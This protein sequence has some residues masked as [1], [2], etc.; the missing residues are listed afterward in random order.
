MY[1]NTRKRVALVVLG[2]IVASSTL[3][4]Q[5]YDF[6]VGQLY[7]K[8]TD[9]VTRKVAVVP[10]NSSD[11]YYNNAPTGAITIPATVANGGNT[12]SI[13]SIG[14]YAFSNCSG[15]T[16]IT[17]PSG[18]TSIE[19]YAFSSCSGLTSITIPSSVTSIG[20][21]AFFDCSGLTSITIPNNVTSIG[22]RAFLWCSGLKYVTFPGHINFKNN[23]DSTYDIDTVIIAGG[24]DSICTSSF[25]GCSKIKYISIPNSVTSIG[26]YAFSNCSGLTSI[27]IPSSVTS[28]G[29]GAFSSCS[30]LTSIT[31]PSSVTSIGGG[32]FFDCSGLTSIIIP[33]S[34]TKIEN[35][36]FKNCTSLASVNLPHGLD[37][38]GSSN[39]NYSWDYGVF[40]GCTSLTSIDI[41][42][43][44]RYIGKNAFS[45]CSGLTSITIPNS[46]TKIDNGAFYNCTSLA[47]VALGNGV[48]FIGS[49][50]F[51]YEDKG[52]F[53]D[54]T[55]LT[56][57]DIPNSVRYIG[58]NAF[59]S[60]SGLT[61]ITIPSGVTSIEERAF[62]DCG[63]LTSITIP[64]SVTK[65]QNG[66]FKNCTRLTSVN[67]SNGLESIGSNYY[68]EGVFEGCTSLTSINI[69]NSVTSIRMRAFSGCSGLNSVT[70]HW[71]RP[72]RIDRDVFDSIALNRVKLTVPQGT[73]SLY[74]SAD[75]WKYF[76]PMV[77]QL[78]NY[79]ITYNQSTN[80]TFK[81]KNGTQE[82]AS[83]S[84][85]QEDT[86]LTIEATPDP[87]YRLDSIKVNGVRIEGFSFRLGDNTTLEVFFGRD[88]YKV[89]YEQSTGGTFRILNGTQEIA[90]GSLVDKGTVLTV[91]ATPNAGKKFDIIK[92]NYK[93]IAGNSFKVRVDTKVE[94]FFGEVNKSTITY[95]QSEGGTFRILNGTQEVASGS[96]VDDGTVL[97]VEATPAQ[98]Y[99]LDSI[100]VNGERIVGL[101]FTVMHSSHI[102]VFFGRKKF[103][104]TYSQPVGGTISLYDYKRYNK[105]VHSG[106]SL[107]YDS[108][109]MFKL[110]PAPEYKYDSLTVN[111]RKVD[112]RIDGTEGLIV[113]Y[114]MNIK[115]F[116]SKP[117]YAVTYNNPYGGSIHVIKGTDIVMSG[118]KVEKDTELTVRATPNAGFALKSLTLNGQDIDNG[119]T[120]RIDKAVDIRVVFS[121][122]TALD[123]A[124]TE[125]LALYPNPVADV[126]YLSA[127]ARTILI[128]D[129]YG[130]EVAHA[131]NTDKVEVSHLPAGVYTVKADGTV[132]KM[133]KR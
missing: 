63:G 5:Y 4:A 30:G 115:A 73:A 38:I 81:V 1:T 55:S 91:E 3:V 16:S 108:W 99:R 39:F 94:V 118:E 58:K 6:K 78:V 67:L 105:E 107:E 72:L 70:V 15:L 80:G 37:S 53:E 46:V 106:D 69:P 36:T 112:I 27:T 92:I 24:S 43:S 18:V 8:I 114:H 89:T 44:V 68:G 111:G 79:T 54:C 83:G 113:R 49:N 129:M 84:S 71:Q 11:P 133:V 86:E 47:S 75:V 32:A 50:N 74:Q 31:I 10:E 76:N 88:A 103:A 33:N 109:L 17:I 77:E 20:G 131:T 104:I 90:S 45:N 93:N 57:I 132:A 119:Y 126:L 12:Y 85:L 42:N 52:A 40:E 64:N 41:P 123:E 21:G 65:I 19:E 122:A 97:T 34:V 95:S 66:T 127:T 26:K 82:V 100:K 98:N 130:T 101:S 87:F 35:G 48:D 2:L 23:F 62:F 56:S 9:S 117:H 59:S 124:A 128:Y 29:G 125:P 7:Y 60:C 28:I 121:P 13:T 110:T 120:F 102:E 116:F 96:V 14:K 22:E 51:Y 25:G 61:S